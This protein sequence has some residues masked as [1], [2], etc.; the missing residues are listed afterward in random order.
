MKKIF[1]FLTNLNSVMSYRKKTCGPAPILPYSVMFVPPVLPPWILK[2]LGLDREVGGLFY[3]F[4]LYNLF[5]CL[6]ILSVFSRPG[7][8]R[9]CSINTLVIH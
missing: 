8:A 2:R 5:F 3:L 9:G 1:D 6:T 7:E 4:S